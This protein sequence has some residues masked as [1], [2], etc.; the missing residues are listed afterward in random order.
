MVISSQGH[1]NYQIG[2]NQT[3]SV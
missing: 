1:S 3:K 2:L